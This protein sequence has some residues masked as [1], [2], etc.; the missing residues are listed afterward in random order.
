[1][2]NKLANI[3]KMD[4]KSIIKN[5]S[6]NIK[7]IQSHIK[8]LKA[9]RSARDVVSLFDFDAI[10]PTEQKSI[11]NIQKDILERCKFDFGDSLKSE[12]INLLSHDTNIKS[13]EPKLLK[14]FQSLNPQQKREMATMISM[15]DKGQEFIKRNKLIDLKKV[16][17][18]VTFNCP[19]CSSDSEL[20]ISILAISEGY[21]VKSACHSCHHT[22]LPKT[23][24]EC[25]FCKKNTVIFELAKE[26]ENDITKAKSGA[27]RLLQEAIDKEEL[28]LDNVNLLNLFAK[29]MSLRS[30]LS[31]DAKSV[32]EKV[33][34]IYSITGGFDHNTYQF[35][36]NI[37]GEKKAS[38][39][40]SELSRAG[41]FYKAGFIP[42]PN[43]AKEQPSFCVKN[44]S[45]EFLSINEF[46]IITTT[47]SPP[48][49]DK[50][51]NLAIFIND[52]FIENFTVDFEVAPTMWSVFKANHFILEHDIHGGILSATN[53]TE[54]EEKGS[55]LKNK[56]IRSAYLK[57]KEDN[58]YPHV[59]PD[60]KIGRL[61][62]LDDFRRIM[63]ASTLSIL[64][65]FEASIVCYDDNFTPKKVYILKSSQNVDVIKN[66]VVP[67]L[68]AKEI[69]VVII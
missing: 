44:K 24:C 31:N 55:I 4:V 66:S 34:S 52:D 15:I 10:N 47:N 11:K 63:I 46:G 21:T 20:K 29:F 33:I 65:T 8:T 45:S 26:I 69:D 23:K 53:A 18:P 1:M 51:I 2:A 35:T 5:E 3:Y 25:G 32:A 19:I 43:Q 48:P 59:F 39:I 68:K 61:I 14:I 50:H 56:T 9:A 12:Y 42:R 22:E 57:E 38:S 40:A 30:S 58:N 54:K 62:E 64:E 28:V 27:N 6:E 13:I 37:V 16:W 7:A 36:Q 49:P 67:I 41:F 17:I 60:I